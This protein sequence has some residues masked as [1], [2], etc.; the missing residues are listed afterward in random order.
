LR[1]VTKE[2]QT[3]DH[4]A[5]PWSTL[6]QAFVCVV[7]AIVIL[8]SPALAAEPP[9]V[10]GTW[11]IVDKK[12]VAGTHSPGYLAELASLTV[13]IVRQDRDS[14]S[15]TIVGPKGKPERITGAFRRDGKTFIYSSEKTAGAGQVQG[16]QMQICRTDAGCAVLTRS[17]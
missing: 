2:L 14:F 6:M 12:P 17:K 10:I 15:G 9:N 16:N 8:A 1:V 13:K 4:P 5:Y 11:S 7:A 3:G